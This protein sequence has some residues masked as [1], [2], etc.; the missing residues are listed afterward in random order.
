[1]K[2]AL[3]IIFD[4]IIYPPQ[5]DCEDHPITVYCYLEGS[6]CWLNLLLVRNLHVKNIKIYWRKIQSLS[7][8]IAYTQHTDY[9]S[10]LY[11]FTKIKY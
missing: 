2:Q 6:E 3:N 10:L 7:I 1:M 8:Y 9:I 11:M 4:C 5:S